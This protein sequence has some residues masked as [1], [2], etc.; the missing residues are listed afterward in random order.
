MNQ[1]VSTLACSLVLCLGVAASAQAQKVGDAAA[2]RFASL[3]KNG[4]GRVSDD[5]YDGAALFRL[6]DGDRNYK[7]TVEDIQ[8]VVG[9]DRDGQLTA[10][11]RI[12][13]ADLNGDGELTEEEVS[14]VADMRF[15]SLDVDHDNNLT[16]AE[17]QS[18]FWRP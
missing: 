4:D 6:L 10:A 5:E 2:Q 8:E 12:R 7:V 18:G 9:P 11:D 3:D 17:F 14:R 15:Q 1:L 13:V 16:F